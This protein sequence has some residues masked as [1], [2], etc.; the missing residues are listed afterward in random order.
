MKTNLIG[1][2]QTGLR[3]SVSA[4]W[5]MAIIL[6]LGV[7][8][9]AAAQEDGMYSTTTGSGEKYRT[10]I[11]RTTRGEL[12]QED[13]RQVTVLSS[14]V[15]LHL[16]EAIERLIDDQS[17]KMREQIEHAQNVASI[18]R[19]MLPVTIVKTRVED[20]NGKTVYDYTEEVQDDRISI[21]ESTLMIEVVK[22]IIE[23]QKDEAALQGL[24]LHDADF[25]YTSALLDLGYVERKLRR[26]AE[27]LDDKEQ[28]LRQLI[29]AQTQGLQMKV[30]KEDSPL[31]KAQAA[32]QLAERMVG[33]NKVEGAKANMQLAR[34]YL[35]SYQS[36]LGDPNA[37]EVKSLRQKMDDLS[38]TLNGG[39]MA[40]EE[41]RDVSRGLIQGFWETVTGWMTEEPGQAQVGEES[42]DTHEQ[43]AD[44][45]SADNDAE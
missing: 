4:F 39:G 20:S 19:D 13:L 18:V 34:L 5:M 17:D 21:Y 41:A 11:E 15:L 33:E 44:D 35:D 12:G 32:L 30:N 3:R 6:A 38:G 22:P 14:R 8:I 27:L 7:S 1:V 40:T 25:I 24:A 2:H 29:L 45:Q 36:L 42:A 26:A 28:A 10:T 43:K 9:N 37:T 23:A 16:N 31:V